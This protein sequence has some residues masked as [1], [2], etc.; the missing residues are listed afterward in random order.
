MLFLITHEFQHKA[1][2]AGKAVTDNEKIGPF[3][4][5]RDLLDP[6]ATAVVLVARKKGKVESQFGIRDIF[7]RRVCDC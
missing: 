7:D 2:F 5:G 4:T 1:N 6:V 3:A